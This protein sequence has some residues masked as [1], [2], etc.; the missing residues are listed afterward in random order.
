MSVTS[1]PGRRVRRR[2]WAALVGL[3]VAAG[4]ALVPT[5]PAQA[6]LCTGPVG[7]LGCTTEGTNPKPLPKPPVTWVVS[8]K[9]WSNHIKIYKNGHLVRNVPV[10]G[11]PYL[12]PHLPSTCHIAQ[13]LRV[14][15]D[16]TGVWRLDYF[17]RLCAGRGVGAHGLPVNRF[18]GRLSMSASDLG[19]TPGAGAPISHG[20]A[21][22][23]VSDAKWIYDNVPI[24][25]TVHISYAR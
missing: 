25:T 6:T 17:T 16:K 23:R 13:K 12:S 1:S 3:A 20:C 2:F 19:K 18:N 14:N 5:I 7:S 9:V 4:L 24:G 10:A 11:N 8:Y 22:M 21:R 15:W